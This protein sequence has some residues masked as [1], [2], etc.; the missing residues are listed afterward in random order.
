M[1][2]GKLAYSLALNVILLV[3]CGVLLARAH[4]EP[5]LALKDTEI[6]GLTA[7]ITTNQAVAKQ[8][9]ADATVANGLRAQLAQGGNTVRIE[10]R[11]RIKRL[12]ALPV[13]CAPG[14]ARQADVNDL[15]HHPTTT[16]GEK[17]K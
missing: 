13:D 8:A 2:L 1:N 3:V 14:T 10:Y 4:Y 7:S 16:T 15:I 6:Q 9:A 5:K 12:P 17:S 11:E